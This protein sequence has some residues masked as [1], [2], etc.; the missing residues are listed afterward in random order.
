[1]LELHAGK[2]DDAAEVI[3]CLYPY[4]TI[5]PSRVECFEKRL[6]IDKGES[7]ECCFGLYLAIASDHNE[8]PW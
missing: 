1:M 4:V 2:Y 6:A 3:S 5:R 7:L 8:L